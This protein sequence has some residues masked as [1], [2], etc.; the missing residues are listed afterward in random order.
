MAFDLSDLKQWLMNAS[1][2]VVISGLFYLI[3]IIALGLVVAA[4]L[5]D[6]TLMN[7]TT[8]FMLLQTII[9]YY[10]AITIPVWVQR[11]EI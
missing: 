6:G 9:A 7:I 10:C 1:K 2:D 8:I 3:S 4:C 11:I 5:R